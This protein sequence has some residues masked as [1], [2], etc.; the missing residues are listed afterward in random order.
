MHTHVHCNTTSITQEVTQMS[1]HRWMEKQNVH[2]YNRLKRNCHTTY[3][4]NEPWGRNYAMWNVSVTRK[5]ILHE[6]M[7]KVVKSTETKSRLAVNNDK[8]KRNREVTLWVFSDR[9]QHVKFSE[10]VFPYNANILCKI[11]TKPH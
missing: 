7:H 3:N 5:Q 4:Q 6:S 8:G 10:N 2:E 9:L 1:F 11:V